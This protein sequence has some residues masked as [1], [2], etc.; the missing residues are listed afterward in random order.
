MNK[1]YSNTEK[2]TYNK[3]F[4]EIGVKGIARTPARPLTV[5]DN[6]NGVPSSPNFAKPL[7]CCM[8]T[9]GSALGITEFNKEF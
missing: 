1:F 7:R 4:G 6:P 3:R 8:Q 9:D 5:S 2:P